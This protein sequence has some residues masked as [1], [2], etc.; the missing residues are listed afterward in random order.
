MATF[1]LRSPCSYTLREE[2]NAPVV[3]LKSSSKI[4]LLVEMFLSAEDMVEKPP[5]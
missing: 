5:S 4:E 1:T 2:G 3:T